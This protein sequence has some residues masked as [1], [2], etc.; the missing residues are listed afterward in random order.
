M[1]WF[2]SAVIGLAI[3]A[4]GQALAHGVAMSYHDHDTAVTMN[5]LV[6]FVSGIAAGMV[7]AIVW[8]IVDER[9]HK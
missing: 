6:S 3:F 8:F 5:I 1:K 7:A 4:L 2:L 9:S